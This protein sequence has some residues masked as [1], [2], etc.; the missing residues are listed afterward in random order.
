MIITILQLDLNYEGLE[1]VVWESTE[2]PNV[3]DFDV[4]FIE[5]PPKKDKLKSLLNELQLYQ[6]SGGTIYWLI[7]KHSNKSLIKNIVGFK[8]IK[9]RKELYGVNT[10]YKLLIDY[11]EISNKVIWF[12]RKSKQW[13][14]IAYYNNP[15]Y[16]VA[17]VRR[18]DLNEFVIPITSE[19]N[20][21]Q[22]NS[23]LNY[24]NSNKSKLNSI[25][26]VYLFL[27]IMLV[28][29]FF[30]TIARE[31]QQKINRDNWYNGY[32]IAGND[33]NYSYA[34]VT[35]PNR[36]NL[37]LKTITDQENNLPIDSWDDY[38]I[39][40]LLDFSM[41]YNFNLLEE[42]IINHLVLNEDQK[43]RFNFRSYSLLDNYIYRLYNQSL[44]AL[45]EEKID[46]A[47]YK[48]Q[49]VLNLV[50][51]LNNR[52]QLAGRDYQLSECRRIV[53]LTKSK[54]LYSEL[55]L[56]RRLSDIYSSPYNSG[57]HLNYLLNY[58]EGDKNPDYLRNLAKYYF[59]D[60]KRRQINSER[61]YLIAIEE[62]RKFRQ[63]RNNTMLKEEAWFNEINTTLNKAYYF[64]KDDSI[65]INNI[66]R[67]I[68][69]SISNFL[70]KY[71]NS[72]LSDDALYQKLECLS[73]LKKK[74]SNDYHDTALKLLKEYEGSDSYV[75]LLRIIGEGL[76]FK[77][78]FYYSEILRVKELINYMISLK[79]EEIVDKYFFEKKWKINLD[80][81]FE[82]S[83]SP[84]KITGKKLRQVFFTKYVS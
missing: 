70:N 61:S 64:N 4:C 16:P 21:E 9:S 79:P 56:I 13:E 78:Y 75:R 62:W 12:F 73:T 11:F 2:I 84:K 68:I 31:K 41:E 30:L 40:R 47:R 53:N 81:L 5:V 39:E 8:P 63:N 45:K 66:N 6:S 46:L 15:N 57:E 71:P 14:N 54:F 23:L 33:D 52:N 17:L 22:I 80:G 76:I 65:K 60:V 36:L 24:H 59:I 7:S 48:A 38:E 3:L 50:S 34:L 83:T 77:G 29:A 42:R 27:L 35:L 69:K 49:R 19:N 67:K 26:P 28:V 32:S 43:I 25:T 10:N 37:S 82:N 55:E 72:Y 74:S 18:R 51:S 20:V 58:S 44:K 1:S